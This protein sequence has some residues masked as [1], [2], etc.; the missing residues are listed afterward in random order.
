[1]RTLTD[2]ER[3]AILALAAEFK[4]DVERNQLLADLDHCTVE[5][6]VPDGSLL[7]FNIPGYSRPPGHKQG[8]YRAKDGF[9]AEGSVK[10]ADG[11]EMDVLLFADQNNRVYELEIVKHLPDSVG[12][13]DWSTFKVK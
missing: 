2:S 1:M 12:K 11:A 13:A 4:S 3:N 6:K 7:V 5:E 10:D 9:R 8:L